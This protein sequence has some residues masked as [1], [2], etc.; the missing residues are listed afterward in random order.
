MILFP[1]YVHLQRNTS[2]KR[3]S[4]QRPAVLQ[5]PLCSAIAPR[6]GGVEAARKEFGR[7]AVGEHWHRAAGAAE[8]PPVNPPVNLFRGAESRADASVWTRPTKRRPIFSVP[9][10]FAW[11][12]P[13]NSESAVHPMNLE[14]C[15]AEDQSLHS[16][17]SVKE[18]N[19]IL[20][21]EARLANGES[22]FLIFL[23]Q[24]WIVKPLQAWELQLFGDY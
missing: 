12:S 10:G 5:L 14:G 16:A 1:C 11:N 4:S 17:F 15:S 8:H 2:P 9:T 19:P 22:R 21:M 3:R 13:S 24:I 23:P 20:Y 18:V 7:S 6:H